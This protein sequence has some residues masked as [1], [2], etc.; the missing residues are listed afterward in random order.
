MGREI[1]LP[2]LKTLLTAAAD[3]GTQEIDA[4]TPENLDRLVA[5]LRQIVK[6]QT[7]FTNLPSAVWDLYWIR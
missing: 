5:R 7:P 3:R 1:T 6:D 4:N 2:D